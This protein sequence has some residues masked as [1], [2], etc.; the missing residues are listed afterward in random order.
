MQTQ[1]PTRRTSASLELADSILVQ[2]A[3]A[4]DQD[5]FETLVHR[6]ETALF[7]MI[8]HYVGEYHE[9]WDVLQQVLLQL[10]LSLATL[11]LQ[12]EIRPWLFT[13]ARHC[14]VNFLRRRRPTYFC[15]LEPRDNVL[16]ETAALAALPDTSPQPEELA[17]HREFQQCVYRA[18]EAIPLQYRPVVWHRCVGNLHFPEIGQVLNIPTSTVKNRFYRARPLLR[19]A[20]VAQL[21]MTTAKV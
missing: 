11:H 7:Q 21:D 4:G 5:A 18:I 12:A 16:D 6:Y 17:E 1:K 20:L 13:V 19:A 3:L 10:Y 9:A 14:C 2:Q 15:E 8:Y